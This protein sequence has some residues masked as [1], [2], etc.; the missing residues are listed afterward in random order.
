MSAP[1][2]SSTNAPLSPRV[3]GNPAAVVGM[4]HAPPLPGSPQWGG[5]MS[6]CREAVLADARALVCGGVDA[7]MLE[8]FGDVPF[9]AD[10]V[11]PATVAALT[12]LAAAVREAHPH[13]PLGLNVLRNDALT[14]AS[15]AAAVGAGFIRVNVLTAAMLTDQGIITGRAAEL[16]RLRASL[17]CSARVLADVRVKHAAPLVDRPME[18]EV[19]DLIHRGRAQGLIVSGSGTGQATRVDEVAEVKAIAARADANVPVLVGS[20][21]SEENAATLIDAGADGLIVGTSL[22]RDGRVDQPVDEARVKS[23]MAAVRAGSGARRPMR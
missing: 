7:L 2:P 10:N 23:L 15:I 18:Q 14:A 20:G 11:P 6:A 17:G 4:L 21:V 8:N 3:R 16:A 22:K 12:V 1:S 9:F 19:F 13:T 5:D